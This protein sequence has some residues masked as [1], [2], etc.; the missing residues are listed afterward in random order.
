MRALKVLALLSGLVGMVG[1]LGTGCDTKL[2]CKTAA[3][4]FYAAGCMLVVYNPDQQFLDQGEARDWC[5]SVQ[6]RAERCSCSDLQLELMD[7]MYSAESV[8]DCYDCDDQLADFQT[9]INTC[10]L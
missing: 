6:D 1:G 9:C 8:G 3:R 10:V 4:N 2:S 5:E 7:C